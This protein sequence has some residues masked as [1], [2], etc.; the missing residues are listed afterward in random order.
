[1]K[2]YILILMVVAMLALTACA[3]TDIEDVDEVLIVNEGDL[4]LSTEDLSALCVVMDK[5]DVEFITE[6]DGYTFIIGESVEENTE[7]T[8]Y[9]TLEDLKGLCEDLDSSLQ[10]APSIGGSNNLVFSRRSAS[11]SVLVSDSVES[12][13][14]SCDV[15]C[16]SPKKG[17]CAS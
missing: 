4:V 14:C 17:C 15:C 9:M 3:T 2:K 6:I 16:G 10:L 12:A 13:D 11:G 8:G 5:S 1:M 7:T